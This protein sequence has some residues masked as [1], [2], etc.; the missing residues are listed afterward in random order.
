MPQL[1]RYRVFA[2]GLLSPVA[3]LVSYAIVYSLLSQA[4][5]NLEK[6]WL[7]R[8]SAATMAMTVPFFV[9]LWL[10]I[11]DRRSHALNLPGKIG[12]AIAILSL[13][14]IWKPVSDGVNRSRQIRNMAMR[15]VPAPLFDTPDIQGTSQRLADY[16][17]KVVVVNIWATWCAP[18]RAEMP[19]LEQ[20]YR[21]RR[22]EGLQVFGISDESVETQ[23]AFLA[24]VPVTYPL[25]TLQGQVPAL[26]RDIAKYPAIFLIDREGNLQPLPSAES[27]FDEI[28]KVADGLLKNR[29]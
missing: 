1:S 16:K 26:Y 18:C 7:F 15:D 12:L 29:P 13:A 23:K 4:S 21:E 8:L 14:L 25:L 22:G 11:R 20:L 17:G 6:D 10:A 27:G 5:R 24:S 28:A 3:A 19:R 9:T 2:V